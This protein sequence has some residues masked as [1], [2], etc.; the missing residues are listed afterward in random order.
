[1]GPSTRQAFEAGIKDVRLIYDYDAKSPEGEPQKWRHAKSP[2]FV[3]L[4]KTSPRSTG[5]LG[6][7]YYTARSTQE[8]SEDERGCF[9]W[10][11][12]AKRVAT[13]RGYRRFWISQQRHDDDEI[14]IIHNK[15]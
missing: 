11:G 10:G 1:M 8:H 4:I 9:A 13:D 2:K 12:L 3:P 14:H 5:K 7:Y 15:S 6:T